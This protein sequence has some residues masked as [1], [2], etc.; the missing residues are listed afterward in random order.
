MDIDSCSERPS[1]SSLSFAVSTASRRL[2]RIKIN[3]Q[4]VSMTSTAASMAMMISLQKSLNKHA[5]SS[6]NARQRQFLSHNLNCLASTSRKHA[7]MQIDGW[8]ITLF[9]VEFGSVIG[10]GGFG[11]VHKGTW[12]KI[13]VT[14]KVL[15]AEPFP[16]PLKPKS[17]ISNKVLIPE[18]DIAVIVRKALDNRPPSAIHICRKPKRKTTDNSDIMIL[19]RPLASS[20]KKKQC[21]VP[22]CDAAAP[23]P[24]LDDGKTALAILAALDAIKASPVDAPSSVPAALP[25]LVVQSALKIPLLNDVCSPSLMSLLKKNFLQI[26]GEGPRRSRSCAQWFKWENLNRSLISLILG[27][28]LLQAP[29]MTAY[30][31]CIDAQDDF[32][33]QMK[34]GNAL[35][36]SWINAQS[37][38]MAELQQEQR[39]DDFA[40]DETRTQDDD[41]LGYSSELGKMQFGKEETMQEMCGIIK[42]LEWHNPESDLIPDDTNLAPEPPELDIPGSQWKALVAKERAAI[43]EQRTKNMPEDADSNFHMGADPNI[44][45]LWTDPKTTLDVR[46]ALPEAFSVSFEANG[47]TFFPPLPI[48]PSLSPPPNTSHKVEVVTVQLQFCVLPPATSAKT[49]GTKPL[50]KLE[51][52]NKELAF[53]FKLEEENYLLFLSA[54]LKEHGHT[55][56]I[57]VKKQHRFGIK[58]TMGGKKTKKDAIDINNFAEYKKIV[59]KILDE[60]P[61]KLHVFLNLDDVKARSK[62][63]GNR[64][65]SS[66]DGENSAK[67]SDHEGKSGIDQEI[68][69]FCGLLEKKYANPA[70]SGYTFILNYGEKIPLTPSMMLEWAQACYNGTTT[71]SKPPNMLAFDPKKC[72]QFLF[73]TPKNTLG[74]SS[75]SSDG[76]LHSLASKSPYPNTPST[77]PSTSPAKYSP[78]KLH[79]FLKHAADKLGVKD[80]MEYEYLLSN[81]GFGPNIL[82]H[83]NDAEIIAC[84]V[85][86]GNVIW[87]KHG[88]DDWW[89]SP[90]A[91]QTRAQSPLAE[92]AGVNDEFCDSIQFKKR[93]VDGGSVSVFGPGMVPGKNCC[94]KE[95]SWWYYDRNAKELCKVPEG[96]VPEIEQQY[97]DENAPLFEPSP[98]PQPE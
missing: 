30:H 85:S 6:T 76:I 11:Q 78:S 96:L 43:L 86:A 88:A 20:P 54:M 14:L 74:G 69:C 36:P 45:K 72:V 44:V 49:T 97:L 48:M 58:V 1:R 65:D 77:V 2:N 70:D 68:A 13:P 10:S 94:K 51:T 63:Q 55:K 47:P 71:T 24:K 41:K 89:A 98:S 95:F 87:L 64:T 81:K 18:E 62:Q 21:K 27:Q 52:K 33:A 82:P 91:K 34:K 53:T 7:T 26:P 84:G 19:E 16:V 92:T 4:K 22:V 37:S 57:P 40:F 79:A 90:K 3:L 5:N 42:D 80:A 25:L 35:L 60:E 83:V 73:E 15:R 56:Y 67:D 46:S 31:E 9:E 12:N 29:T 38:F 75:S 66:S 28:C 17:T 50:S 32:H 39:I 8:S 61:S 93:Y 59:E 23:A